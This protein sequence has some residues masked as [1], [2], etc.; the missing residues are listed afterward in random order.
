MCPPDPRVVPWTRCDVCKAPLRSD[1]TACTGSPRHP[2]RLPRLLN[3]ASRTGT[4]RNLGEIHKRGM[5]LL[6]APDQLAWYPDLPPLPYAL[7]NGAWSFHQ[8]GEAFDGDMFRRALDR[9]AE[10]ADWI[11]VPDVVMGGRASLDLSLSW[12]AEVQ[13][14]GRPVLLVVQDG[15]V[16]DD[17]AP[18]IGPNVGIF[19]GG[20]T[21]W[22]ESSAARWGELARKHGAYLHIGRVNTVRRVQI[23]I[24]AGADSCD[25]TTLTK[26]AVN[27]ERIGSALRSD[28]R[29][30]LF[31]GAA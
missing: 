27:A 1:G 19:V 11:A 2:R 9:Y 13:E 28:P 15:M 12:L 22:K 25:G 17:L 3:Y 7:D 20:S 18:L 16:D 10:A 6:A 23:A 31:S 8:R 30:P 24:D 14:R 21:G 29:A 26:Y 5:R 4:A